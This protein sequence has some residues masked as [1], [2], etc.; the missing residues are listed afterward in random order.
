MD[1]KI[2]NLIKIKVISISEYDV[3]SEIY[4]PA[5]V[6]APGIIQRGPIKDSFLTGTLVVD[7]FTPI[8]RGQRELIIGDRYTGKSTI[9]L[10]AVQ[11]QGSNFDYY[12]SDESNYDVED[13]FSGLTFDVTEYEDALYEEGENGAQSSG[14][15]DDLSEEETD[16]S[17]PDKPKL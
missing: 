6:K 2:K 1:K 10:D 4:M 12:N 5:E 9:A 13:V 17:D 8:G 15:D 3:S 16:G 11:F 7:T 14:S